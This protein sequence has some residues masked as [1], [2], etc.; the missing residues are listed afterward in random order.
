MKLSR[1]E[2]GRGRESEVMP[3]G[4]YTRILVHVSVVLRD[5]GRVL[6]VQEGK[7]AVSGRWNL[8]GGHLEMGEAI[9]DGA[10]R[11]VLEEAGVTI[12]PLGLLGVYPAVRGVGVYA[13]RFVFLAD[14]EDGQQPAPGDDVIGLKWVTPTEAKAIA[15]GDLISHEVFRRVMK[16][17]EAGVSYPL[18]VIVEMT[19][20]CL[21]GKSGK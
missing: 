20:T 15:D 14:L 5:R 8:P 3:Q 21:G 2:L 12:E 6:I 1:F 19:D 16:D 4:D 10:C 7:A 9:R 17:V 13:V 18:D 11:E